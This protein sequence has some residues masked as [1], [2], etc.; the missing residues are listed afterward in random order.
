MTFENTIHE[1]VTRALDERLPAVVQAVRDAVAE[2]R[3]SPDTLLSTKQVAER[4]GKSEAAV[5]KAITRQSIPAHKVGRL[6]CVRLG[7]ITG[8]AGK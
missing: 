6:W 4:L 3:E 8:E 2:R 5:L 1:I 7:D